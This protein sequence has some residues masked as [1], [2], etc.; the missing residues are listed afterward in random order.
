MPLPANNTPWPPKEWHPIF[1]DYRTWEAWWTGD[2]HKLWAAYHNDTNPLT[3][4]RRG[5]AGFVQRFF[6]GRRTNDAPNK[7]SRADLH[8]PIAADLA[9]TT[10][11]ILYA[12]P[13]TITS[14]NQTTSDR[15]TAYVDDG[16]LEQLITGAETGAALAGRYHRVTWDPTVADQ[17]FLHTID[18]DNALPEFRWGRLTA[19]TFWT[20]LEHHG[21]TVLRH[22]ERHELDQ[23]GLGYT[24]H[25]LYE[26]TADNLGMLRPLTEH[27]ATTP[28]AQTV[29]AEGYVTQGITP[30]LPVAYIPNITPNRR[31]R[32]VNGAKDLGRSVYDGIEPLMDALDE[33]YSAWMRDLRLGKARIFADRDMLE[34]SRPNQD[35][36]QVFDLDREV[37][38]PLDGLA[39]SMAD[40]VPIQPQQFNIRWQEHQQTALDL[41]RQII[42][43][44]RFSAATF[45]DVGDNDMTATEVNARLEST[46]TT[47]DRKIR[48]EKPAVERLLRKMLTVDQDI[49]HTSG[50]DPETVTVDFPPLVSETKAESM[51]AAVL[52]KGAHLASIETAVQMAH[53]D[54]DQ[55]RI[56]Q[57][58]DAINQE[59]PLMSPDMWRPTTSE[60]TGA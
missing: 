56:T 3:S 55:D 57:E 27:P 7:P 5:I 14:D 17:P 37:F 60:V 29:G 4:R 23:N 41:T 20:V 50:L 58:V 1:T 2:T 22:L 19:V 38:T 33:T 24:F 16:L 54:W 18:A 6:W 47:R 12:T 34:T 36:P 30:G 48:I 10:A 45:S 53:P 46:R 44:A 26:G 49:Y 52:L 32:H 42:R 28:L 11:D 15:L 13:P 9:T 39:G 35:G 43:G 25:G 31:W 40:T 51:N 59:Q 8:I 21:N